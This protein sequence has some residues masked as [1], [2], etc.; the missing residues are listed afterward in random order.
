MINLKT[1]FEKYKRMVVANSTRTL[2]GHVKK[3]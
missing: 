1:F 3:D 2:G